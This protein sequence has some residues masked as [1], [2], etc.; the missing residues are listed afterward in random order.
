MKRG[1]AFW[2]AAVLLLLAPAT[3]ALAEPAAPGAEPGFWQGVGIFLDDLSEDVSG[4]LNSA[5]EAI[6]EG[7]EAAAGELQEWAS[8]AG[9]WFAESSEALRRYADE[10]GVWAAEKLERLVQPVQETFAGLYESLLQPLQES[11]AAYFDGLMEM[12]FAPLSNWLN[13][14]SDTIQTDLYTRFP[15]VMNVFVEEVAHEYAV[16]VALYAVEEH[17]P[18]DAAEQ[19]ALTAANAYRADAEAEHEELEAAIAT[20]NAWLEKNGVDPEAFA[21]GFSEKPLA[22][23]LRRVSAAIVAATQDYAGAQDLALSPEMVAALQDLSDYADG[24]ADL[25][26]DRQAEISDCLVS[27]GVE[28]GVDVEAYLDTLCR[29]LAES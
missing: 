5:G 6:G 2:L 26:E 15:L 10:F 19:A 23:A 27:W 1:L 9:E 14:L 25:S 28:N 17:L 24:A 11:F 7:W 29:R 12:L 18:L 20:L 4:M 13:D 16:Q 8:Q 21:A 22:R 3:A